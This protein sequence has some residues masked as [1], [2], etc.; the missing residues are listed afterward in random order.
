MT[1]RKT[2]RD[3]S[4]KLLWAFKKMELSTKWSLLLFF[5]MIVII[6]YHYWYDDDNDYY[7]YYFLKY[8]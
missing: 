2:S 6:Y 1:G 5:I 7:P 3:A 4:C 8:Y